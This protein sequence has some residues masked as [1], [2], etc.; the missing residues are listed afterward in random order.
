FGEGEPDFGVTFNGPRAL[1]RTF[2][3]GFLGFGEAYMDEEI[4]VEGSWDRLFALAMNADLEKA[5]RAGWPLLRYLAERLR[6]RDSRRGAPRNIRHHYDLGNDFYRLWLD[7]SMTYSCAYFRSPEADLETAQR[8]KLELIC[9][10]LALAPGQRL[11]DVGCGWG[12]LAIHAARHHGVRALGC[13]LSEPQA[14]LARQRVRAAGLEDRVEIRVA[15]YRDLDETFDRWVSVGMAEHVGKRYLPRFMDHIRSVMRPG[16]L[17]L[18]HL[19][20]KDHPGFG[21][22][23]TLTYI[24]PGG[25][26]PGLDHLLGLMGGRD[27]RTVDVEN[28]R[29]HYAVTLDRWHER[30]EEHVGE[31]EREYGPRF[32]RMWRLF[33]VSSAAGF[34]YGNT[35]VF[36]ILF[37]N[38]PSNEAPTTRESWYGDPSGAVEERNQPPR[39]ERHKDRR[40]EV[41]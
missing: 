19:I 4:E 10:K 15:D 28:L 41:L 17:G 1:R 11:L 38:G 18:L 13:T 8:D 25:Y 33:L 23:W 26:L 12:S 27:L 9:R 30:F 14:E 36:Q 37:T 31:I 16:G 35:R 6:D 40:R 5:H 34:R 24:F 39:S 21:D 2:S 20:G 7:D 32:V 3:A 22:P 29:P